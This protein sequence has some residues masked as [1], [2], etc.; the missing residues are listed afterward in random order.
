MASTHQADGGFMPEIP[1][2]YVCDI[3]SGEFFE[4]AKLLPKNLSKLNVGSDSSDNVGFTISTVG[5][6]LTPPKP[7]MLTKGRFPL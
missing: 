7:Q 5:I 6:S 3:K 2:K 4:L 1:N